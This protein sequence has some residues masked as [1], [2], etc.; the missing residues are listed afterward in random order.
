M[1]PKRVEMYETSDGQTV[2]SLQD[3]KAKELLLAFS[4]GQA[5]LA[6]VRSA[7]SPSLIEVMLN[8]ADRIVGILSVKETGRPLNRKDSQPRKRPATKLPHPAEIEATMLKSA[9][10]V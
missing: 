4:T 2:K 1:K 10:L 7:V 3:W 9:G 5:S 8:N 6:E